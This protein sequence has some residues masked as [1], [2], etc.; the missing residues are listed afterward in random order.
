MGM[1]NTSHE[2]EYSPGRV[3]GVAPRTKRKEKTPLDKSG[4]EEF[5]KGLNMSIQQEGKR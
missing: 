5:T 1:K 3:P 4:A 2:K